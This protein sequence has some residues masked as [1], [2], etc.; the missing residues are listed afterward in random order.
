M[1]DTKISALPSSTTPL[2]GTEVLPIVQSGSTVKVAVSDLTAGRAVS[3]ASGTVTG[4]L[5]VD[6]S[7][8]KVDST[9]NR[10]GI[11]TASPGRLLELY[12]A[13]SPVLRWNDSSTTWD[14]RTN[15]SVG[16]AMQ[17]DYN[18]TRYFTLLSGGDFQNNTGNYVPLTAAKGIN[19][20]ANTPAAGMTSQLLNWYEQGTFT[21]T[22]SGSTGDPTSTYTTQV[23]YYTRVG[24]LVTIYIQV[25]TSSYTGGSGTLQIKALPFAATN[26]ARFNINTVRITFGV[27][28]TQICAAVDGASTTIYFDESNSGLSDT[29]L[30]LSA[31]NSGASAGM[32]IFGS[33]TI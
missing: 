3:M 31:W 21:P 13:G 28:A 22:L 5:S 14:I 6:T 27:A 24:N 25:F 4:D 1:A 2:A 26:G 9:N 20:T 29:T 16:S 11:G 23:G 8:L 18:G 33:Y 32:T 19:F 15:G 30:A 7:T 12:A 10:V 17:F